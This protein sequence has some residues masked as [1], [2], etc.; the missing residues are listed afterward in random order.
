MSSATL[1]R[2]SGL[3]SS[4]ITLKCRR[5]VYILQ[6]SQ[7][8]SDDNIMITGRTLQG[9]EQA[10]FLSFASL[11]YFLLLPLFSPFSAAHL[12]TYFHF[13][14]LLVH[15]AK[16]LPC[17]HAPSPDIGACV[18]TTTAASPLLYIKWFRYLFSAFP[19]SLFL[20]LFFSSSVL[21]IFRPSFMK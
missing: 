4:N 7:I 2:D 11:F 3:S 6:D 16:Y 19:L 5:E 13:I 12:L 17:R 9:Y 18:R 20:F 8:C 21:F 10:F 14:S 1:Q 15:M